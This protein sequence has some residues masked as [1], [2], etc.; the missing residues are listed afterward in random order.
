MTFSKTLTEHLQ[1]LEETFTRFTVYK[2][3][4]NPAKCQILQEQFLYLG[5]IISKEGIR[6]DP[7]K[8]EAVAKMPAPTNVKQLRSFLGLCNYYRKFIKNYYWHTSQLYDLFNNFRWTPAA[9]NDF[10]RLKEMLTKLPMRKY[11]DY[12]KQ[13][14]VNTDASDEGIG[15]VLS[16]EDEEGNEKVIQ[17]ISRSLQPAEKK[18]CI[19]EKE[20]L[21]I[22]YACESFRPYLYGTKFIVETDHHSLQ[23]LMKAVTPARLVRWAL[24]LAEFDFVIRYKKGAANANADAL[25]R[26]PVAEAQEILNSMEILGSL[27]SPNNLLGTIA[28]QQREDNELTNIFQQ[29]EEP[30]G[31]PQIPFSLQ[32]DMLYFEKYD[33]NKLLVIP[34]TVIPEILELYHAHALSIHMSRDRLY[35]LLRKRFYWPSLFKDVNEWVAACPQCSKVKTNKPKSHGLLKPIVTS[36]PFEMLAVDI[37]GPLTESEEGY[38]YILNCIDMFTS[39][40]EAIPLRTLTAEETV[41]AITKVITRHGCP[42]IILSDQGTSFTSKLFSHVCK[43]FNITHRTSSAYHHQTIEKVE[44]FHKFMENSLS[45]VVRKDQRNWPNFIDSCL[46]VY[47]VSYNRTLCEV[48]FFL[49][50]G[51]DPILPQDLMVET[52]KSSLR[53]I[54]AEELDI[55]KSRLLGTIKH[56]HDKLER[57]KEITRNKYKEYYDKTHREI[58]Y[59]VGDLVK[60]HFPTSEKPGLSYKLGSRWRGPYKIV[61]KIDVNTYRVRKEEGFRIDIF[62]DHVQRLK[63]HG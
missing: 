31:A 59:H 13:F 53:E 34:R 56:A 54:R 35:A 22:I 21:A 17:Y 16:Q 58:N 20:G 47:R 18:W 43:Y 49:L 9:Y 14:L 44:R 39:W 48:P 4:L 7:K 26:L 40:P 36:K 24:K 52:P 28:S 60:V 32:N 41:K 1:R 30:E 25:S 42:Q 55:Y 6:P 50:Y 57:D 63:R 61:A 19:R 11:L 37:M 12:N 8:I 29:L 3:K 45:T 46:F 2:L 33:G 51:R 62:P 38:K 10:E 23:W 15:A 27:M 5:H